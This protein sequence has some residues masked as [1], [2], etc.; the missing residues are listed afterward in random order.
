MGNLQYLQAVSFLANTIQSILSGVPPDI[1][2][3]TREIRMRLGRSL[4]IHTGNAIYFLQRDGSL[5]RQYPDSLYQISET[6]MQECFKRLCDYSV[7]SYE[8]QIRQGFLTIQG[9]H[10][11]GITGTGVL[12][13]DKLTGIRNISSINLRLARQIH[14]VSSELL[15]RLQGASV[16]SLLIAGVPAS[17]KTTLLKDLVRKIS[18]GDGTPLQKVAVVDSRGEIAA[19]HQGQPQN[20][21]GPLTDVL[22]GYEKGEGMMIAIKTM[23]PQIIVCDEIGSEEEAKAIMQCLHTGVNIIATTH[24]DSLKQIMKRRHI[25]QLIEEEAFTY[26]VLL[27]GDKNPCR[28]KKIIKAGDV[29]DQSDG[30]GS[31]ILHQCSNRHLSIKQSV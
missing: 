4:T 3:E 1:Q 15:S 29:Y 21:L 31:C 13:K 27:E 18:S 22:D 5:T 2:E 7:H 30:N 20:D 16:P 17:G 12:N 14:H 23:S 6:D 28:I 10:R 8:A 26:I 25:A 9:G 11:A 24:A 19:V